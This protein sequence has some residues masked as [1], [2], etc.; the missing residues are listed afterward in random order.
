MRLLFL[1]LFFAAAPLH[2][3]RTI[4]VFGDSLSSGYGLPAGSGWVTLL[5]Q[6]LARDKFDYRVV[7]ASL[8]GETTLGGRNRIEAVLKA[9]R[10]E[11]LIVALGGNDGLRGW[12]LEDTRR[13]LAAIVAAGRAAGARVLIVGMQIPPNYGPDYARGF[14]RVFTEVARQQNAALVPFMLAGF[15]EQTAMFQADGIHPSEAAQGIM[16]DNIYPRLRKLLK[17]A[18]G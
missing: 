4:V 17:R 10:P 12:P 1:L 18:P 15:A 11:I 7:N 16:L 3:A 9:H 13:N 2:A 5:E 14:S 8:T 6:R